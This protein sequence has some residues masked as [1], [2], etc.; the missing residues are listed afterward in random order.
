M[1]K[2]GYPLF[3]VIQFD[4][5]GCVFAPRRSKRCLR[6]DVVGRRFQRVDEISRKE[7]I[8][9]VAIDKDIRERRCSEGDVRTSQELGEYAA[10]CIVNRSWIIFLLGIDRRIIRLVV[11]QQ[12]WYIQLTSGLRLLVEPLRQSQQHALVFLDYKKNVGR[13]S[14]LNRLL[15]SWPHDWIW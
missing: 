8:C 3:N 15:C 11:E 5:V 9:I 4:D 1:F 13:R 14:F 7:V 6:A 2:G 10:D 12:K